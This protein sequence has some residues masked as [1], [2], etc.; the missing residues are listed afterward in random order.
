[1]ITWILI[2]SERACCRGDKPEGRV[3]CRS[4][5]SVAFLIQYCLFALNNI[6]F[7]FHF[8]CFIWHVIE[9]GVVESS[10]LSKDDLLTP[11]IPVPFSQEQLT[12]KI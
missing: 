6:F 4:P 11:S 7:N 1:M 2:L 9:E 3:V 8:V 10:L 5:P 12:S